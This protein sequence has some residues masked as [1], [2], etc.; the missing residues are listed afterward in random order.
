MSEW[1]DQCQD[2]ATQAQYILHPASP[3]ILF[4]IAFISGKINGPVDTH[5]IATALTLGRVEPWTG[6]KWLWRLTTFYLSS[7]LVLF[8]KFQSRLEPNSPILGFFKK[9][10][11]QVDGFQLSDSYVHVL[12]CAINNVLFNKATTVL[13][14]LLFIWHCL[15]HL[16]LLWLYWTHYK[17]ANVLL[18]VSYYH[19]VFPPARRPR[20]FRDSTYESRRTS[21]F[22]GGISLENFR[23]ISVLGRGHFGKVSSHFFITQF[24]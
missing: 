24:L 3:F 2:A 19:Q 4:C 17:Y 11:K 9:E 15:F 10:G 18:C 7:Y 21:Q 22:T 20:D 8:L 14:W 1:T 12:C 5:I 16:R 23:F 13:S 6:L